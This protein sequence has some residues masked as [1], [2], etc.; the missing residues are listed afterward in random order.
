MRMKKHRMEHFLM[1]D[2]I[3]VEKHLEKMAAKGWQLS[4]IDNFY[5]T[6]E[7][8]EPKRLR[9]SVTYIENASEFD[10]IRTESKDRLDELCETS[11][12]ERVADW[13]H[14]QVYCTNDPN[15]IDID[16]DES[17]RLKAIRKSMKNTF[18]ITQILMIFVFLLNGFNYYRSYIKN[19]PEFLAQYSNLLL[20]LVIVSAFGY[21]LI[22]LAY[23]FIWSYLSGKSVAAGGKC[24]RVKGYRTVS[25]AFLLWIILAIVLLCFGYQDSMAHIFVVALMG[26]FIIVWIVRKTRTILRN[27]G[28]DR[29]SA[30]FI[31][32]VVDVFLVILLVVGM[33]AFMS[34]NLKKTD[35]DA[36]IYQIEN[37]TW[38]VYHDDIPVKIEALMPVD[39]KHYS[40]EKQAEYETFLVSYSYYEQRSFPD[41]HDAPS[42]KY[43]V[44][45][46]K[47]DFLYDICLN[48]LLEQNYDNYF[49]YTFYEIDTSTWPLEEE[50]PYYTYIDKLYK[51]N[52]DI[53]ADEWIIC[54]GDTI[55]W[56]WGDWE[57]TEEQIQTI[58]KSI[59]QGYPIDYEAYDEVEVLVED[60]AYTFSDGTTADIWESPMW[61]RYSY[62]LEDGTKILDVYGRQYSENVIG[63]SLDEITGLNKSAKNQVNDYLSELGLNYDLE[64]QL[65]IAYVDYQNCQSNEIEFEPH[66][67]NEDFYIE[68][69]R[70]DFFGYVIST[71]L[72]ADEHYTG[73]VNDYRQV[74]YFDMETG[75]CIDPI[76]FFTVS[77]E[78]VIQFFADLRADNDLN[79][80][81]WKSLFELEYIF[82]EDELVEVYFPAGV[83]QETSYG[84]GIGYDELEPIL[85][86]WVLP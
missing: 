72:P 31:T 47:A 37:S 86:P 58:V 85:Q 67:I 10:P 26:F 45:N 7:R 6:Y 57:M 13:S 59:S 12:W 34:H 24:I 41:G 19:P 39:Y 71:V 33:V 52:S 43:S 1:F 80:D 11:G 23:Y 15:A 68:I 48:H 18:L 49:N 21:I 61:G 2:Y 70:D 29:G 44:I 51:C 42:M 69:I 53:Y 4:E 27:K 83:V 50:S 56:V 16:T 9:Y 35:P 5:W 8:K 25:I 38:E 32:I 40:Y 64:K 22:S 76:E 54:Q 82:F 63:Q 36:E 79:S 62:E 60:D 3:G 77:E 74:F 84:H 73:V 78:D 75:R 55:I 30:V 65:E 81:G 17:V 14:M 46:V 66:Y 20:L 28:V